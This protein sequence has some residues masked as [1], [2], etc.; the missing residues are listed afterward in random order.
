L[1]KEKAKIKPKFQVIFNIT[2]IISAQSF[3]TFVDTR[4]HT[5]VFIFVYTFVFTSTPNPRLFKGFPIQYK[6][7]LK[8]KNFIHKSEFQRKNDF[9]KIS[10]LKSRK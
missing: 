3:I 9:L 8:N 1:D 6:L 4:V 10:K 2:R 5:N 7:T